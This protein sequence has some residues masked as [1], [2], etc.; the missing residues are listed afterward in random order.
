MH[1]FLLTIALLFSITISSASQNVAS[2]DD[3]PQSDT[4]IALSK[5]SMDFTDSVQAES[6]TVLRQE[7]KPAKS[8]KDKV[9][10]DSLGYQ[11][12]FQIG[13]W[14][15]PAILMILATIMFIR[16]SKKNRDRNH[17]D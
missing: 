1:R 13:S 12:G 6:T 4:T 5:D 9:D 11:I 7:A 17:W 2:A 10:K 14:L 16:L 15:I 3:F 8:K